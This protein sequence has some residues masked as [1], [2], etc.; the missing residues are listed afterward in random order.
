MRRVPTRLLKPGDRVGQ[1]VHA[2]HDAAPLL[3]AGVEICAGFRE[4]LIA[5]GI[6]S[7]WI[8][9]DR[10]RGIQPIELLREETKQSAINTLR[11]T[12][13]S[14]KSAAEAGCVLPPSVLVDITSVAE[15]IARD[16]ES[17][18]LAA[19]ALNDLASADGYSLKHS[20]SVTAL[21]LAIGLRAMTR[22][23]W[24]DHRRVR[25]FDQIEERL[26][27]LGIGL[28]LHD[29]GK[30]SIPPEIRHKAGPL[31]P[32][33]W[34]VMKT[35][36][37]LGYDMVKAATDISPVSRVVIR[38]HHERWDGLG[39]PDGTVGTHV[40][41]FARIATVADVF[42]A[43]TSERPYK[44]AH[45]PHV[46]YHFV[47]KGA[48]I[49]FD[50][51]VVEVFKESVAPYP[52]GTGV[53]L[54]DGSHAVVSEVAQGSVL[55][56]IIRLVRDAAGREIAPRHMDL[57]QCPNLTIVATDLDVRG[58]ALA[59]DPPDGS[60]ARPLGGRLRRR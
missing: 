54:S 48:D 31:T 30:A 22:G 29:I 25:R 4:A 58:H 21:G 3:R 23:G 15:M 39:Y 38:S 37:V 28:L 44:L 55:R 35:H 26:V 56:P 45:P 24:L 6:T 20:L 52:P 34:A 19:I 51:E 36:P 33:E 18:A 9:D 50:P 46:A 53:V 7:V 47:L 27:L 12:F 10:S 40:H 41:Q 57:R 1:D 5:A 2:R 16:I 60:I 43:I 17:S 32:A 13:A 42:D 59:P 49:Q 14:A 8:D 11:H